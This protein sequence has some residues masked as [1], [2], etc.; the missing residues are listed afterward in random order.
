MLIA[1]KPFRV[2]KICYL[3]ASLW[4]MSYKDMNPEKIDMLKDVFQGQ[5]QDFTYVH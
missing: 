5:P 2:L 1:S 3:A 4:D